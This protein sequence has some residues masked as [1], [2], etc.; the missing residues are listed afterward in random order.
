M[1]TGQLSEL[2][3]ALVQALWALG[4]GGVSDVQGWLERQGRRLAPTTV[5]TVL[6]RLEAQG[7]VAHREQGRAFIYRAARSRQRATGR[8]L[9]RITDSLFG[10]DVPALVSHLLETRKVDQREIDEIR[11]LLEDRER[12]LR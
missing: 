5:A 1:A 3:L 7:W 8:I 6:R 4:E 12:R 2:Q 10:G 9:A 11:R